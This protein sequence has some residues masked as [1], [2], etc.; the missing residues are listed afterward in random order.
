MSSQSSST[1]ARRSPRFD[2]ENNTPLVH[3]PAEAT[4]K[5]LLRKS[6]GNRMKRVS[7]GGALSPEYFDKYLP[8]STPVRRG[9]SPQRTSDRRKSDPLRQQV[10]LSASKKRYSV[11]TGLC[12]VT[13]QEED[14]ENVINTTPPLLSFDSAVT[15][16]VFEDSPVGVNLPSP[17]Q[18]EVLSNATTS[19]GKLATPLRVQIQDGVELK[20]TKKKLITP[21][22]QQIKDGVKLNTKKRLATPVRNQIKKRKSLKPLSTPLRRS[23]K[24]GVV[25]KKMKKTLPTP[26][27]KEIEARSNLRPVR[28]KLPTPIRNQI[29][30]RSNLR[31]IRNKLSTPMREEIRSKPQLK[32]V[33][34]KMSKKKMLKTP[35]RRAIQSK[36]VLRKTLRKGLKTPIRKQ[37][38]QG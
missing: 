17:L 2:K 23:I 4:P 28:N 3:A 30:T 33:Q 21:L 34:N 38:K 1:P 25:L 16:D 10:M 20:Q 27:R 26:I 5:S 19:K 8:P 24:S 15:V 35:L 29:E 12:S 18:A 32:A 6:I 36:P 9:K 37:I 31:P 7:F 13:I 14:D 22:R 11:N